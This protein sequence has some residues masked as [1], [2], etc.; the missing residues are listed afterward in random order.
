M[1]KLKGK[2]STKKIKKH[3]ILLNPLKKILFY[4]EKILLEFRI[5]KKL[6]AINLE[7]E[8]RIIKK[9]IAQLSSYS[10]TKKIN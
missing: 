3:K 9:E 10:V 2:F 8:I 1:K 6:Q 7:R 4:F 5:A